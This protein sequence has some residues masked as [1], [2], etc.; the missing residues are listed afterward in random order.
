MNSENEIKYKGYAISAQST[1]KI[2]KTEFEKMADEVIIGM[3]QLGQESRSDVHLMH[4][5]TKVFMK[6]RKLSESE[7][8]EVE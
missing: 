1:T 6:T 2:S 4:D 3:E 8:E 5:D 7:L